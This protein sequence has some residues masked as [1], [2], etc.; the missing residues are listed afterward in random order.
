M[1]AQDISSESVGRSVSMGVAFRGLLA[2]VFGI[3]ALA[4]PRA[5]ALAFV[6]LFAVWAFFDAAFA[7]GMAVI[8][9]RAGERWV[10]FLFE[11]LVSIAGGVLALVYPRITLLV[12]TIIVAARAIV[13]G[14]LMVGGA[15]AWKR[16]P[17][18]WLHAVTGVVSIIFGFMLIA[19]PAVG[20]LALVW[21]VG[22]YALVFG[23]MELALAW[24]VHETTASRKG[25]PARP[26]ATAT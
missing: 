24:Q 1:N 5:T 9:G 18:R 23:I 14:V 19:E 21:A 16:Q 12:L 3:I 11:G 15:L 2:I 25:I 13:L 10:W 7:L 20:A 17:F 8:R 6:I 22:V 26:I 4:S